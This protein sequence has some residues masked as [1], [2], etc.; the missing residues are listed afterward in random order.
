MQ[1]IIVSLKSRGVS[2]IRKEFIWESKSLIF[3]PISS[4]LNNKSYWDFIISLLSLLSSL[5][6]PSPWPEFCIWRE[7]LWIYLN[8]IYSFYLPLSLLDS[9]MYSIWPQYFLL[10]KPV[11][12]FVLKELPHSSSET[13]YIWSIL[14]MPLNLSS[15][16]T[17]LGYCSSYHLPG[18]FSKFTIY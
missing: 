16:Y 17:G 1:S 10:L 14:L 15:S 11:S 8:F 5:Y 4:S 6:V 7:V 9:M 2:Y 13:V 18:H 12:L 3:R